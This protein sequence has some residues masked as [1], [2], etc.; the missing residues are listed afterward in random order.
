MAI[1]AEDQHHGQRHRLCSC[2]FFNESNPSLQGVPRLSGL[3]FTHRGLITA[4]LNHCTRLTYYLFREQPCNV[5]VKTL[6]LTCALN[7]EKSARKQNQVHLEIKSKV[8]TLRVASV[9]FSDSECV[10]SERGEASAVTGRGKNAS[11]QLGQLN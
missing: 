6:Y 11:G 4:K 9:C 2:C 3:R 7:G 8:Y 1:R 10:S 5:L